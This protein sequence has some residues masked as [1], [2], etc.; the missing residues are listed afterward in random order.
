MVSSAEISATRARRPGAGSKTMV[1]TVTRPLCPNHL[2][3]PPGMMARDA[4]AIV[5]APA[6]KDHNICYRRAAADQALAVE[7]LASKRHYPTAKCQPIS[8]S[9]S[10]S[11][12][13]A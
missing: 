7:Y 8:V 3:A 10:S 5:N 11:R 13:G 12:A 9:P 1:A 4:L 2:D 6:S